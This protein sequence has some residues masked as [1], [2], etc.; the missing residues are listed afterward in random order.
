MNLKLGKRAQKFA[1][2]F[3]ELQASSRMLHPF[4]RH[5]VLHYTVRFESHFERHKRRRKRATRCSNRTE[6]PDAK[7]EFPGPFFNEKTVLSMATGNDGNRKVLR[8]EKAVLR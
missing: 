6:R 4:P 8:E 5:R 1:L 2:F 3:G 7:I